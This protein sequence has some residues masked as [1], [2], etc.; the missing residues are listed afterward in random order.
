[1]LAIPRCVFYHGAYVYVLHFKESCAA[2]GHRSVNLTQTTVV[3]T[4]LR[5]FLSSLRV[6]NCCCIK[7][8]RERKD[9]ASQYRGR[10]RCCAAAHRGYF[11]ALSSSSPTTLRSY[12][13]TLRVELDAKAKKYRVVVRICFAHSIENARR[14]RSEHRGYNYRVDYNS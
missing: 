4:T 14:E 2:C 1:M 9:T 11:Y 5:S 3:Y 7:S 10:G 12:L 8:P 13:T 6:H